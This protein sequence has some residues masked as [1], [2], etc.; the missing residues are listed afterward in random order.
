MPC[1]YG[2]NRRNT[3]EQRCLSRTG[4]T[5]NSEKFPSF[6]RKANVFNGFGNIPFIAIIFLDMFQFQNRIHLINLLNCSISLL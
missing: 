5:H 2:I 1:T 6:H 4:R 3:V